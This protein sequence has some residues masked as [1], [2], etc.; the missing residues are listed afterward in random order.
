MSNAGCRIPFESLLYWVRLAVITPNEYST[1]LPLRERTLEPELGE[2]V[3]AL[4][5]A[6]VSAVTPNHEQQDA[7]HDRLRSVFEHTPPDWCRPE[8]LTPERS[9]HFSTWKFS[10]DTLRL[11]ADLG[12]I[13]DEDKEGDELR[14]RTVG[15]AAFNIL[16]GA[17]AD[18]CSSP[19]LPTI[20]HD[21][22]SFRASCNTLL[23]E[24]WAARGVGA[25]RPAP[26]SGD[27]DSA[28]TLCSIAR[29]GSG[30]R[31][32]SAK[33]LKR[34][35]KLRMNQD[36][37]AQRQAFRERVD[38]YVD[39]LRTA[40]AGERQLLIDHWTLE[41]Q[42]DRAGLKKELRRAGFQSIVDKDGVIALVL[43]GAVSAVFAP[44]A[45]IGLSA[46][47]GRLLLS[48]RRERRAAL[49]RHWS[50]WL[51]SIEKPQLTL[52]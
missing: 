10:P 32:V 5:E 6:F 7:V 31:K 39:A 44:L 48:A 14:M 9:A 27:E 13:L 11:L 26:P 36:F 19:T 29:L 23:L 4:N 3:E 28:F 51:F 18:E 35:Y 41:L 20:T 2:A 47:A 8:N 45:A 16:L 1:H 49:E 50:S 30:E 24:V 17:L 37:D 33:D 25:Q 43:V 12:W 21:P 34:L 46:S 42:R 40:P 52:R 15:L 38:S 22:G